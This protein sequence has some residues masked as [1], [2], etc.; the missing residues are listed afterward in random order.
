MIKISKEEMKKID[1]G[2]NFTASFLGYFVRGVDSFMDIG[3]SLGSA[4]RRISAGK[5]CPL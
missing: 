2:I 4:F 3:R 5:V 1:G